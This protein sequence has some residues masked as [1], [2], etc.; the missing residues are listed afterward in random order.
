[1]Q[2]CIVNTER[3]HPKRY[4]I[5]V[6]NGTLFEHVY[7]GKL[8]TITEAYAICNENNYTIKACGNMWHCLNK[9]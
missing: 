3:N 6:N 4:Q 1:M 5:M 2:V 7:P 8:F 9:D